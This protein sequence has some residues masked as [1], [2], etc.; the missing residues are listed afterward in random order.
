MPV[1]KYT[2]LTNEGKTILGTFSAADRSQLIHM[3][4]ENGYHP[5]KVKEVIEKKDVKEFGFRGRVKTQ[6]IAVFCRQFYSMLNAGVTIV[7]GLDILQQQTQNKKLKAVTKDLY[8]TVQKGLSLSEA[9]RHH[10]DVFP[11]LLINMVETGEVSGT[12]DAA[13]N[14][15]AFHFE[16]ENKL[17]NKIRAAMVYPIILS[18]LAIGVVIFLLTFVMPMFLEMF[19]SSGVELPGPTRL[20]LAMSNGLRD[21]WYIIGGVVLIIVYAIRGFIKSEKGRLKWDTFVLKIPVLKHTVTLIST[22]R[23]TRTLSTLL[24]SGIPLLQAMEVVARVVSNK[25]ASNAVLTARD[26]MRKGTDLASPIKR[27]AVFPPMVDSMIKIGEESGT[28]D[29]ILGKTADFYEDELETSL[30]KLASMMEPLVL[31]FMGAVIGK[32]CR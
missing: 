2:A 25:V 28:L 14:R 10:G 5:V 9:M 11:E 13:M 15:M 19:T 8:E 30:Q 32:Y 21:Y 1:Y 18:V 6:D 26:D 24:S 27:A 23:F 29:E 22:T 17:K 3:I 20:L 4:R 7:K 31:I 16:K 12:I